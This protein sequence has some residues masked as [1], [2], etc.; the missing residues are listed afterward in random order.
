MKLG[1]R[2][3]FV[4]RSRGIQQSW[5]KYLGRVVLLRLL[6]WG[7]SG[8]HVCDHHHLQATPTEEEWAWCTVGHVLRRDLYVQLAKKPRNF[9]P[10]VETDD[11]AF[12]HLLHSSQQ[13]VSLSCAILLSDFETKPALEIRLILSLQPIFLAV[14]HQGSVS[15]ETPT[16]AHR[17]DTG[18]MLCD[19]S[20]VGRRHLSWKVK[21]CL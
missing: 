17:A 20:S 10:R 8:G 6:R 16:L 12:S 3:I 13:S 21:D 5:W 4:H 18:R 7:Q 14:G 11:S 1:G 2:S 15:D 19:F 9:P